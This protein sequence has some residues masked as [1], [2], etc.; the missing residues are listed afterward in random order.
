M[1]IFT[2]ANFFFLCILVQIAQLCSFLYMTLFKDVIYQA[3]DTLSHHLQ[4]RS[5]FQGT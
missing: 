5:S 4:A 1:C 3:G 2:K